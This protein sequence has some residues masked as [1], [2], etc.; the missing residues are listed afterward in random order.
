MD[1]TTTETAILFA[2]IAGST[3]LYEKLG[4]SLAHTLVGGCLNVLENCARAHGGTVVKTIGDEIMCTFPTAACAVEASTA[5]HLTVQDADVSGFGLDVSPNLYIGIA[6][7]PVV[8]RNGDVFGDAVNVAARMVKKAKQRQTL[9]TEDVLGKL[10]SE[11]RKTTRLVETDTL[12]GKSG[13]FDIHEIVWEYQ[14]VTVATTCSAED[15]LAL[16]HLDASLG[17]DSFR[18]DKDH[19]VLTMG[20][21]PHNDVVIAS[22][23]ASRSHARIEYRKGR[24]TLVD[25]ST[26]GTYVLYGE[27]ERL[28]RMDEL[29]LPS[30]GFIGLGKAV[31]P[32]SK[33]IIRY[34]IAV[35]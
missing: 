24:F 27:E 15:I 17:G 28:V 35:D 21:Q 33:K 8:A 3:T 31:I 20:R 10:P 6:H 13:T 1:R 4:N 30:E 19:P 25:Q 26:N 14:D 11:I 29:Q 22:S 18:V 12:K 23:R 7:G 34:F 2:D 9:T 5:M 16:A 32:E